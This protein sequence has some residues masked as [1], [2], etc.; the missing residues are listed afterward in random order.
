MTTK[1]TVLLVGGTG[2]TGGRV[3]EQ[4]LSC[5]I[6]VRAIVRSADRLPKGAAQDPRLEVAEGDLLSLSDEDLRRSVRGC[7]AVISCLGHVLS[8]KGIF[9][10]PRDLV[11]QATRRLCRAIVAAQPITPV[12][13]ILMS[14][15]SV[16]QPAGRDANR[17]AF[18]RGV[19]WMLR[20]LLP[21]ARDNQEAADFLCNSVGSSSSFVQWAAVRPDTLLEGDVSEY[22]LHENLVRSLFRP[23]STTMANVAHFMCELV[24]SDVAWARWSGKLPVIVNANTP[25]S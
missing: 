7:D 22:T 4:L 24:S 25:N 1:H 12:K 3:L 9:G 5:G 13:F 16:N 18:E 2:R 17:G 23:D 15:V 11:T 8:L 6:S 10:P 14:S 19:V 21:P 20:A